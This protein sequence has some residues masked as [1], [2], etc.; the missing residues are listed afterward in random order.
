MSDQEMELAEDDNDS[1]NET[2]EEENEDKSKPEEVYLPNK[3]LDEGEELICDQSA[4]VMLHQA[5][6]GAPC[7]SFDVIRDSLGDNRETYPLTAYIVAGTQASQAHVNNIIVM[8]LS[9]LHKTNKEEDDDDDDDDDDEEELNDE[10]LK[11]PKM[12]G[13]LIKHQGCVNR[14][15][16]SS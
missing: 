2:M 13:A 7:L 4:Y 8:K 10:V 3:P 1:E 14:I 12:A 6:T 5:Q 15:R 9:N 11:H 16:V